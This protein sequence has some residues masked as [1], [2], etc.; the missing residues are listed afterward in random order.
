M[1]RLGR[2][3]VPRAGEGRQSSSEADD[4]RFGECPPGRALSHQQVTGLTGRQAL[5]WWYDWNNN[6]GPAIF[7]QGAGDDIP[8]FIPMT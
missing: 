6:A 4:C 8:G 2:Y 3:R 5:T 1:P 7:P